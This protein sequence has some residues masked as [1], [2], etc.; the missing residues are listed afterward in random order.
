MDEE[1]PP[2]VFSEALTRTNVSQGPCVLTFTPLKGVSTVVKR[3]IHEPS[4][5]RVVT[6]MTFADAEHYTDEERSVFFFSIPNTNA[7]HERAAFQQWA[8]AG[9][10]WLMKKSCWSIVRMP[11]TLGKG[12]RLRSGLGSPVRLCGALV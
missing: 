6:T 1:P 5:D 7:P 4:P 12:R 11:A 10:S 2:D 3:Y 9:C 8:V